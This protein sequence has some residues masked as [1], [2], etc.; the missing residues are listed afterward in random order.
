MQYQVEE[1]EDTAIH[2]LLR[3]EYRRHGMYE[4]LHL[5]EEC[6]DEQDEHGIRTIV[7]D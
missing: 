7:A 6:K 5:Y 2:D 1:V 3:Q 4:Y